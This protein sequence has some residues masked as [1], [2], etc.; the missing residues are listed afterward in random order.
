MRV[1]A[2]DLGGLIGERLFNSGSAGL[3]GIIERVTATDDYRQPVSV[4][5]CYEGI[6]IPG[7]ELFE[8]HC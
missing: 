4:L 1:D 6:I 2:L 5:R 8:F 7:F 3:A